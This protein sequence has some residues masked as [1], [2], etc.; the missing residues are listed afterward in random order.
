MNF[1]LIVQ[2]N[3]EYLEVL[4]SGVIEAGDG[5]AA[6]PEIFAFANQNKL[7]AVLF[8]IANAVLNESLE[9]SFEV[10]SKFSSYGLDHNVLLAL[11]FT[12]DVVQMHFLQ[13]FAAIK[14]LKN[15]KFFRTKN[16]AVKWLDKRQELG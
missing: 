16:D 14:Q 7:Q 2:N 4:F 11:V 9:D 3:P 1:E 10:I 15:V 8:N 6:L 13:T 12:Q 5:P